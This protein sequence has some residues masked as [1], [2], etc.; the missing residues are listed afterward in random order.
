MEDFI[1]EA[2]VTVSFEEK[3]PQPGERMEIIREDKSE[4]RIEIIEV[5]GHKWHEVNGTIEGVKLDMKFRILE[6][7]RPSSKGKLKLV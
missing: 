2:I 5:K 6:E 1:R 3:F 4:W 7:V